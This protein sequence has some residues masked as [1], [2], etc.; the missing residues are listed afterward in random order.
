MTEKHVLGFKPALLLKQ[1][2]N[3]PSG[4]AKD[5]EIFGKDEVS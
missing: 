4:R 5:C 3:E 1:A 2:G